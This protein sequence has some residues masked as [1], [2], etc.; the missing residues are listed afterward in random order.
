M[1]RPAKYPDQFR[2]GALALVQS[3][4][5]PIAEVARSEQHEQSPN[6]GRFM[7]VAATSA[8]SRVSSPRL[9]RRHESG[10]GR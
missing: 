10:E 2:R 3:S 7:P 8:L 6:P 9:M 1:G 4:G 5:R